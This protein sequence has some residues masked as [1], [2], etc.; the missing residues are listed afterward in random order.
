MTE[1][2]EKTKN[3]GKIV[4][5]EGKQ[6]DHPSFFLSL[7]QKGYDIEIAATGSV[8]IEKMRTFRPFLILIDAASLRTAGNRII[9]RMKAED[10]NVRIILIIDETLKNGKISEK[11]DIVLTLPFQVQTLVNR[12][13]FFEAI[14]EPTVQKI[15]RMTFNGERNILDVNGRITRLTPL[16]GYLLQFFIDNPNRVILRSEIF[17]AVWKSENIEDMRTLDVHIQWLRSAIEKNPKRPKTIVTEH[18]LGY[19]LNT[20]SLF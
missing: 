10:P 18:G 8:A 1:R 15:G 2:N 19:R 9:Y 7:S 4:L 5:I 14:L 16:L 11:A 17:S 6:T 20:E 12:I 3:I 13:G